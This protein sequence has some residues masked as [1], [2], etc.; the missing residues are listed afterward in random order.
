MVLAFIYNFIFNTVVKPGG[1]TLLVFHSEKV[2]KTQRIYLR[3]HSIA[4]TLHLPV[5]M[6]CLFVRYLEKLKKT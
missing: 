1:E 3:S 5:G 6:H 4:E 2:K